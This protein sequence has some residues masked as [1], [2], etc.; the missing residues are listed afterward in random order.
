MTTFL[1]L[2]PG[3]AQC[4]LYVVALPDDA[5]VVG[6]FEDQPERFT[7]AGIMRPDYRSSEMKL[8]ALEPE[9]AAFRNDVA[10]LMPGSYIDVS[11]A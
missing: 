7:I 1:Y 10:G 3:G 4:L 2:A 8:V 9:F 5:D 11:Q 6:L